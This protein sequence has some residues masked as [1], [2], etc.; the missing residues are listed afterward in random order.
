MVSVDPDS[1]LRVAS[2]DIAVTEALSERT[3]AII[4]YAIWLI[5]ERARRNAGTPC[6]R[7][8]TT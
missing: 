3:S 8:S 2:V 7:L 5:A 6:E 1:G 4:L